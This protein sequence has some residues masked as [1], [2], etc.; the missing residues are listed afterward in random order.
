M[1]LAEWHT[2]VGSTEFIIDTIEQELSEIHVELII[3]C[4]SPVVG[5]SQML[6]TWDEAVLQ[7]LLSDSQSL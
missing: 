6:K 5:I 7:V 2:I 1:W 3:E 4:V